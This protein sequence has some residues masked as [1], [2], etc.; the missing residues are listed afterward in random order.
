MWITSQVHTIASLSIHLLGLSVSQT[1]YIGLYKKD[2]SDLFVRVNIKTAQRLCSNMGA[3]HLSLI[4]LLCQENH[5]LSLFFSF[6]WSKKKKKPKQI[7]YLTLITKKSGT[8][9]LYRKKFLN[10]QRWGL[11]STQVMTPNWVF[12]DSIPPSGREG[13]GGEVKRCRTVVPIQ[14]IRESGITFST[15]CF[16]LKKQGNKYIVGTMYMVSQFLLFSLP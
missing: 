1:L 15:K 11:L 4:L 7:P 12:W 5:P 6:P 9:T 8:I 14:H 16:F 2:C 13:G 10:T 3:R